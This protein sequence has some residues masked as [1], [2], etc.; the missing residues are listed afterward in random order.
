MEVTQL[1]HQ[2]DCKEL[3]QTVCKEKL[4]IIFSLLQAL[5]TIFE[6]N[7]NE[8]CCLSNALGVDIFITYELPSN[9]KEKVGDQFL[10]TGL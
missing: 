1:T 2:Q 4:I 8:L 6:Q 3:R 9:K 10:S 7:F 5:I